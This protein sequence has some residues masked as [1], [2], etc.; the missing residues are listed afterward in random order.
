MGQNLKV[1]GYF[2]Q[3]SAKLGERVGYVLKATYPQQTNIVFPDSTFGY[4]DFS[5]LGKQTFTSYTPDSMTV[6]SA[7]YFLSNFS[8]DPV[9]P[10]A[11]PVFEI[12]K[13]DS[14]VHYA[15]EDSLS[16]QL[17]I[18]PLPE[19]LTFKHN[20]KYLPVPRAFNYPILIAVLGGLLLVGLVIL[21]AFGKKI[22]KQWQVRK[23]G[24]Q[25]AAFLEQWNKAV[26]A[27]QKAP[28][29]A[30]AEHL[31]ALWRGYMERLSG[32]PYK[33]WTATEIAEHLQKPQLKDEL[34]KIEIVVYANKPAEDLKNTCE[35]LKAECTSMYNQKTQEI[36]ER[37]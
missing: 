37:K 6:D 19:E 18:D 7:V 16:L 23:L 25:H 2:L 29:L 1:E 17:T 34:R 30:E 33:E 36:H 10:Y 5:F 11:L 13:F 3:D 27:M 31:L 26:A 8:L 28:S 14:L 4:R 32:Q 15:N 35:Q 22:K 24:K 21:L 12:L 9:K 20:D